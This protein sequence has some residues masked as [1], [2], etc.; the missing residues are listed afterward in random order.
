[1][2]NVVRGSS[3]RT[4]AY[5]LLVKNHSYVQAAVNGRTTTLNHQTHS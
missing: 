4:Q 1:M 3:L 2:D 5:T